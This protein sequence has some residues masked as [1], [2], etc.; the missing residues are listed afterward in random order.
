L[1]EDGSRSV[2]TVVIAGEEYVIRT[3]ATPDYTRDCADYL[4]RT[5]AGIQQK[6]KI[7]EGHKTAIL[8]ALALT[9]QLFQARAEAEAL[10]R[11]IGRLADRLSADIE[12]KMAG[13]DL[14]S[15]R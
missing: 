5:I 15:H 1:S 7:I 14:A 13:T 8:A 9:D 4:D 10:H 2:V 6:S 11:E 3:D 12:R